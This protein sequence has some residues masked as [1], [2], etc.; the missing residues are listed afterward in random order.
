MDIK[1][2]IATKLVDEWNKRRED[3]GQLRNVIRRP[4]TASGAKY[5]SNSKFGSI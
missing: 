4:I 3:A 2:K 5:I 1:I